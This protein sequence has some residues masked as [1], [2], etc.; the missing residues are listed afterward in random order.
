[1]V[2]TQVQ[3]PDRLYRE[4]R[5]L[6]DDQEWSMAEAIRRGAELLLRSYP[7]EREDAE[8]WELPSLSLGEF[9]APVEDWRALA[10]ARDDE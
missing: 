2:R 4:L 6:A 10:N 1:M 5:K 8:A 7:A 9:Q 3:L